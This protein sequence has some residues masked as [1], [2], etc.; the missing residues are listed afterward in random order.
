MCLLHHKHT[1][2]R[3][4][5]QPKVLQMPLKIRFALL[6]PLYTAFKVFINHSL[7]FFLLYTIHGNCSL[8]LPKTVYMSG[9]A[10]YVK[11]VHK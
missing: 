11:M 9:I 8:D 3:E 1:G 10:E 5:Y 2:N 7:S 4:Y 6:V